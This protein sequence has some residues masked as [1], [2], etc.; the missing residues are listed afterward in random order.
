M[1]WF[2]AQRSRSSS[3][4]STE[5]VNNA[6]N[7]L[8]AWSARPV[9]LIVCVGFLLVVAIATVG[10][11]AIS[12][13]RNNVIAERERQLQNMASV[14]ADHF[15]RT[16]ESLTL[17]QLRLVQHVQALKLGSV[18]DFEK[19]M[20]GYEVHQ[21]L[22]DSIISLRPVHALLLA[23][24]RGKVVNF[25]RDWPVASDSIADQDYFKTFQSSPGLPYYISTPL[26]SRATGTWVFHIPY[27]IVG[28]D[29]QFLGLII[30]VMELRYFEQLFAKLA[31]EQGSSIALVRRDGRL[32]ARFPQRDIGGGP[33]YASNP[34]FSD[35]LPKS[36]SGVVRLTSQFDKRE[37]FVAGHNLVNHL[38]AV[39]VGM[40]VDAAL[41]DW[42]KGAVYMTAVASMMM[43]VLGGMVV[44]CA[45]QVG[46]SL[47]GQKFRLDTALNHMSH[48]LCMFD[49]KG[50]LVLHNA[51]YLQ[52]FNIPSGL[53]Q[54]GYT[55]RQLLRDLAEAGIVGGEVEK[56]VADLLA[57][58]NQGK[59]TRTFRELNDGRTIHIT[60]RPLPGGG[61]VATHEDITERRQA[62]AQ[63][64][65]MAHHDTLTDLPN[66]VQLREKLGS[67]L[68]RVRRGEHLAVLYLDLDHFKSINDTLGHSIGD[69]LLK[70]VANRLRKCVRETDTIAR[71][72]GDEFAI[73]QTAIEQPSDAAILARRVREA[74]AAPYDLDDHHVLVDASIG[75]SIAPND[76]SESDQLLKNA[77]MALYGAK[78]DG[79]GTFRFFE[80][81]MDAR[82]KARRALE[83]DLR[84]AL[85][86][87]EFELY[88][89]PLVNLE[90]NEVT[91]CEALLRWNHPDRG[92]ISPAEFIPLA[93][94]TGLIAP[95]GEWVLTKACA[96]AVS[97]PDGIKVAV[98][99]SPVQ[100]KNQSLVLT[101]ISALGASDLPPRR[102]EIEIT[103]AVLMQDNDATIA[104]LHQLRD[105]G[106][107]IAM[108][109]FGTGYSSLSYLR[110]F[111]FDKI[112]IDRS[113]ISGLSDQDDSIAIVRA[114]TSLASSLNIVTT[115][116][117]VETQ[118]QLEKIR[119]LGCTEMQGYLF[120]RPKSIQDIGR[121]FLSRAEKAA[122][123]V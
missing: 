51:R 28:S 83:L 110:S 47:N 5:A 50:T 49:A 113:F 9:R 91:G 1:V 65:H 71:L 112:K 58:I 7:L 100:F 17:T 98:N 54:V 121:F 33:S 12:T 6:F 42:R 122:C 36:G 89:Q 88:Y 81:E 115:A 119:A 26:Q 76:A 8:Q 90:R 57:S 11:I 117:G 86:N 34:L 103:E 21:M 62:E 106:V 39:T 27:R 4:D 95:L 75:I 63:I 2:G 82:A 74:V 70:A 77:D 37:R 99:V 45:L 14:L 104:T 111:P 43:L 80:P 60:N 56:Y 32:L 20:T 24:S 53:V 120:S 38:A 69:E 102:L 64:A 118:P 123:T 25:S 13:L 107:R 101:V 31:L 19:R 23:S 59:T 78:N 72:G 114:V 108:D 94:E 96:D 105:L 116:E 35:I 46:K 109:D 22:K 61:W 18:D 93:E 97:W 66:R 3:G 55:I 68:L 29:G 30:G 85:A 16:F 41:A 92:M 67:A 52:I 87:K 44:L 73:I 79:R 15:E 10:G 40:E 48:G 84:K